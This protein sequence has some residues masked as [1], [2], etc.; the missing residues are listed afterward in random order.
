MKSNNNYRLDEGKEL[1][2]GEK[3]TPHYQLIMGFG[4]DSNF[5]GIGHESE[6]SRKEIAWLFR[7]S[8]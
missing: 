2:C 6:V 3:L 7:K 5:S 4:S 1:C 8:R